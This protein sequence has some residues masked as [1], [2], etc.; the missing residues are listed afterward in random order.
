M[1]ND[2]PRVLAGRY[3]IGEPIGRGGM[4]EV[5][6]GKDNRLG[7]SVAIKVL[8][9][10]LA[11]DPSFHTRFQRE[12][13][14][15]ASLNHPA[16]VSV[17]DTGDETITG[18]DGTETTLP[19]IVMEYV[20]GH[21]VRD[22]L[23]DGTA[24][25]LDEAAEITQGVLAALEYSHHAGIVHRDIKP[26]NVMLT[27]TGAVKVMDFGIA[28]AMADSAATMTQTQAVVGTAQYLSPE[29]ARGEVVDARSDLYSTGCLLYELLTGQPPFTG[30][31]AVS[32]AY[33][34]VSEDARPPSSLASD[35]PETLD[36]IVMKA[37]A[38]DRD[39][40][41]SS[42]AEFR[43]DLDAAVS[44][45]V[46]RAPAVGAL[47]GAAAGA[48]G[49]TQVLGGMGA[50]PPPSRRDARAE[51]AEEDEPRSN[52][53]LI[54]ILAAIGVIAAVAIVLLLVNRP[55][56]EPDAPPQVAVPDLAG[57]TQDEARTTLAETVPVDEEGVPIEGEDGLE[58]VVGDPEASDEV[59]AGE[60]LSWS[61]ET[62]TMVEAGSPV[63][64]VF[65]AGP[66]S[67][68][69][70]DVSGLTQEQARQELVDAGFDAA[71]FSVQTRD[72]PEVE[73]NEVIETD[74]AA[75]TEHP[76]DGA[77]VIVVGTGNVVLE[78]LTDQDLEQ[79]QNTLRELGLSWRVTEQEDDGTPG[80]VLSQSREGTIPIDSEVELVVSIP[81]PEPTE[82]PTEEPTDEPTD[83][84]GADSGDATD[85]SGDTSGG[86]DAG[87]GTDGGDAS[88]DPNGENSGD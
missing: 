30:D 82:E 44:D 46:V 12:A 76:A 27:P 45:G 49:A 36:R 61:P 74:P 25:P 87:A 40:R 68:T 35:I 72:E 58:L 18:S 11:R 34:H 41:Y 50:E 80:R 71:N 51:T 37:L 42:A 5:F 9:S 20:E 88:G 21:T 75:Q 8:R 52:K 78:D 84:A 66:D 2:V 85:G 10:D 65:S 39:Q 38:K 73:E 43:S 7:R 4:A 54:W 15:A 57:M 19:F 29:Q 31:S 79:A 33:Q 81:A 70:P 77:I 26:A 48:A 22:L 83:D 59:P 14:S 53:A 63:T 32:V 28:R 86:P 13:Q 62:D 1:A 16:I 60:A 47:A 69:I 23:R 3:E 17:Y 55:P 6:I 56:A 64:V 24:L 67:F